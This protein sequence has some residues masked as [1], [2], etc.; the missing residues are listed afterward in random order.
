MALEDIPDKFVVLA[1]GL[2]ILFAPVVIIAM[3]I[4]LLV[5]TGDLILEGVSPLVF[6]ELYLIEIVVFAAF[7]YVLYRLTKVLVVHQLPASL[8]VLEQESTDDEAVDT[9]D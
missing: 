6:L 3:T 7:T 2:L 8:S 9:R 5:Y 4:G 1:I